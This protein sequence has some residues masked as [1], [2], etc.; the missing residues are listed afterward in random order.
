M[1]IGTSELIL[2]KNSEFTLNKLLTHINCN[3]QFIQYLDDRSK[4][5]LNM[6]NYINNFTPNYENAHLDILNLQEKFPKYCVIR[7]RYCNRRY[8]IT[9]NIVLLF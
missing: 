7:K 9:F 4:R 5:I 6:D 3:D 2:P 1:L 8:Q